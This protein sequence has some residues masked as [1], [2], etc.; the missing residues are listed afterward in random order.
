MKSISYVFITIFSLLFFTNTHAQY[1]PTVVLGNI[2]EMRMPVGWGQEIVFTEKLVA[3]TIINDI[4]YSILVGRPEIHKAYVREDTILQNIYRLDKDL[5]TERL[6]LSYNIS[7]GDS[8]LYGIGSDG[9]KYYNYCNSIYYKEIYGANRKHVDLGYPNVYI[10]GVGNIREGIGPR[11]TN[12]T[13]VKNF[14]PG[15]LGYSGIG[16]IKDLRQEKIYPNPFSDIITIEHRSQKPVRYTLINF[17]GKLISE[18][19]ILNKGEF[20]TDDLIPG[21]YFIRSESGS[22]NKLIKSI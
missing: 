12:F 9:K 7:I 18:K 3:D 16:D 22:I 2:W 1:I 11:I 8:V 17:Y 13:F 5:T 20:K 15:G 4:K 21:I 6:W 10:E 19:I 14:Y